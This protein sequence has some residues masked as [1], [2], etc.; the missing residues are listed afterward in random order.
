MPERLRGRGSRRP[1][2]NGRF[3]VAEVFAHHVGG[4]NRIACLEY[5]EEP[6][7]QFRGVHSHDVH[8]LRS[9]CDRR[10]TY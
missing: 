4:Q 3:A 6:V 2:R 1:G 9:L 10:D 8:R 7:G 5:P